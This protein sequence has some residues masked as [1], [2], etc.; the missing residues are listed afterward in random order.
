MRIE[1]L[2]EPVFNEKYKIKLTYEEAHH[3]YAN[4]VRTKIKGKMLYEMQK[5]LKKILY[6]EK[7]D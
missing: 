6:G 1:E 4:L 7:N 5:G 3:L 2:I